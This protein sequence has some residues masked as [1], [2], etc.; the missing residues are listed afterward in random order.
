MPRTGHY[1]K[2]NGTMSVTIDYIN[3]KARINVYGVVN[4]KARKMVECLQGSDQEPGF[5]MGQFFNE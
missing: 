2:S 4:G 3:G 1:S 5:I